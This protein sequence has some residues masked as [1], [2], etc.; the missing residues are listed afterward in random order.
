MLLAEDLERDAVRYQGNWIPHKLR[1]A[2]EDGVFFAGDSAGPL[3]AAD[4]RGHP[5]GVLLRHRARA[6]AARGGRGALRARSARA[7]PRLQRRARV[8]VRLDAARAAA[9]AA[10]AAAAAARRRSARWADARSSHWA[11]GHYLDIAPPSFA[12]AGAPR[13]DRGTRDRA[14]DAEVRT[15]RANGYDESDAMRVDRHRPRRAAARA[16]YRGRSRP[17]RTRPALARQAS[18]RRSPGRDPEPP[19]EEAVAARLAQRIGAAAPI[20]APTSSHDSS[21]S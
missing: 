18:S 16:R 14:L 2:T 13:A 11:F 5:H 7:L 15:R 9:R 4:R 8:E 19:L 20:S 17:G 3:P 12:A 6:R 1:P 10:R 21:L